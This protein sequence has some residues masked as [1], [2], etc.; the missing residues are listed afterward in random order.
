MDPNVTCEFSFVLRPAKHGVGVFTAHSIAKGT[1]LNLWSHESREFK[2][3]DVPEAFRIYCINM[4]DRFVGP[5]NFAAMDIGWY[6]NHSTEPNAHHVGF[7]YFSSRDL[8]EGEEITIDYNTLGEPESAKESYY[9][10]P[11]A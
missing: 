1:L 4:G 5:M 3:D 8:I 7:D 11:A 2:K 10:V 9:K 6:L